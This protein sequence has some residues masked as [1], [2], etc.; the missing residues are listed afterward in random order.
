[1]IYLIEIR[2][3][4]GDHL[5]SAAETAVETAAETAAEAAAEAAADIGKP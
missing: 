5:Q 3:G 1:M 4:H 2:R